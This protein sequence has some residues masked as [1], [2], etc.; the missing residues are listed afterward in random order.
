MGITINP[1]HPT[2]LTREQQATLNNMRAVLGRQLRPTSKTDPAMVAELIIQNAV[3]MR[4]NGLATELLDYLQRAREKLDAEKPLHTRL[5]VEIAVTLDVIDGRQDEASELFQNV[6]TWYQ[7]HPNALDEARARSAYGRFLINRSQLQVALTQF[8]QALDLLKDQPFEAA[9]V[10][11]EMGRVLVGQGKFGEAVPQFEKAYTVLRGDDRQV[12]LMNDFAAALVE[13]GESDR[14]EKLL[15][16]GI[17]IATQQG[18]WLLRANLRRQIAYIY[19][20]RAEK[21]SDAAS[22][23]PYLDEAVRLLNQAVAEMLPLQ[24]TLDLAV[25]YHDLGRIEAQQ[26]HFNEAEAHLRL[27]IELFQRLGNLRNE[28]VAEITLGTLVVLKNGDIAAGNEHLHRALQLANK[29]GDQF[30]LHQAAETL[31]RLHQ[32][33]VTRAKAQSQE[34]RRQVIDQLSFS[35][36]RLSEY[37]LSE[38]ALALEHMITE[39]EA[40]RG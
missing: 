31:S 13:V 16:E 3:L 14:A 22:A 23:Q 27:S 29:V 8:Q 1:S 37:S 12:R 36:A 4:E 17:E 15:I 34:I 21:S 10:R 40:A 39:L 33:Q 19:H 7:T 30:T 32:L 2:A 5:S 38:A 24:N 25:V 6:L 11:G 35:R 9:I 26:R 20:L 18:L 28:A